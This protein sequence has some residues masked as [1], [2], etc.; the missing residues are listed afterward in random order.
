[1]AV[2]GPGVRIRGLFMW[3]VNCMPYIR[4]VAVY[5]P[6]SCRALELACMQSAR[7]T[8]VRAFQHSAYF[9]CSYPRQ[10]VP[11]NLVRVGGVTF[12]P[13]QIFTLVAEP[14]PTRDT[15]L[16]SISAV[17][18]ALASGCQKRKV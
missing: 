9:S 13:T 1:M 15:A 8:G 11:H 7:K 12:S 6:T 16:V 18:N 14:R 17:V 3:H 5:A 10:I 2:L 4:S